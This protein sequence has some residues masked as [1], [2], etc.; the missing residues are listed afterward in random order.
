MSGSQTAGTQQSAAERS[1]L[2]AE[3]GIIPINLITI[4]DITHCRELAGGFELP[5][6][7]RDYRELKTYKQSEGGKKESNYNRKTRFG[8]SIQDNGKVAKSLEGIT[9]FG[10]I[11]KLLECYQSATHIWVNESKLRV[12]RGGGQGAHWK[13]KIELRNYPLNPKRQGATDAKRLTSALGSLSDDTLVDVK[14]WQNP[15]YHDWFH[16]NIVIRCWDQSVNRKEERR[17]DL[18]CV[19]FEGIPTLDF[20][21]L[22]FDFI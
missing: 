5:D 9:T 14:V 18:P 8:L 22:E 1:A 4:F 2:Y 3:L 10:A 19:V 15:D 20:S 12:Q 11:K 16:F 7:D 21:K 6:P 17:I 13:K